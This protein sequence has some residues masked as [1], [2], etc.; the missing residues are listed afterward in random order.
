M[1][2]RAL[3]ALCAALVVGATVGPDHAA[4]ERWTRCDRWTVVATPDPARLAGY[5]DVAVLDPWHAYAVGWVTSGGHE[6]AI[7]AAWNGWRWSRTALEAPDVTDTWTLASV[8]ARS[9]REVWAVGVR[10]RRPLVE[11]F[12]GRRWRIVRAP[13]PRGRSWLEAVEAVPGADELWAVG[14]RVWRRQVHPFSI[15]WTGT[16][17]LRTAVPQAAGSL[18]LHGVASTGRAAW[19]VG[20][21]GNDPGEVSGAAVLR[22]DG[23]RWAR[24]RIPTPRRGVPTLWAID[25]S[26]PRDA[27]AV[28]SSSVLR[29][30]GERWAVAGARRIPSLHRFHPTDVAYS[31]GGDAWIVGGFHGPDPD[32]EWVLPAAY[33]RVD[34]AWVRT[35]PRTPEGAAYP[36]AVD[37]G[38]PNDIWVVGQEGGYETTPFAQHRC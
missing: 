13:W 17:W 10:G 33:H 38:T 6:H 28:G 8:T 3:V 30:N 11:R 9:P 24:V 5:E 2:R 15:R 32:A 36:E 1:L 4:G 20:T 16:R 22:W 23:E 19:A 21:L 31:T 14:G 7:A 26:G 25:A 29:W 12:D 37:A 27:L 35:M 34:G 18:T